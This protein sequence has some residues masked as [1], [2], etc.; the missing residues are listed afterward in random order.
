MIKSRKGQI[1][2]FVIIAILIVAGIALFFYVKNKNSS[3]TPSIPT[4]IQPV[5]DY[6][7]DCIQQTGYT[8]VYIVGQL[9]GY[10]NLDDYLTE[11]N[12]YYLKDNVPLFPS[13]EVIEA[14]IASCMESEVELCVRQINLTGFLIK[15][16]NPNINILLEDSKV[17]INAEYPLVVEKEGYSYEL[18]E[19]RGI[20]L[21]THLLRLYHIALNIT[22]NFIDDEGISL[23]YA[24]S[25]YNSR[26]ISTKIIYIDNL[27]I[28][29]LNDSMGIMEQSSY[30]FKFVLT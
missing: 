4:E 23:T 30:E 1:T 22:N 9:G 21:N 15:S 20:D 29:S 27:T 3:L 18:H 26:G 28:I 16:K 25:I 5:Y 6:V 14:N 12:T 24:S 7:N 11:K 17:V 8:A 2:I 13:K 19:F 10:C